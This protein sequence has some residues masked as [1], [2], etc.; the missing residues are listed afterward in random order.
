MFVKGVSGEEGEVVAVLDESAIVKIKANDSCEKCRL[1]K[2]VSSTEMEVEA[3]VDRPVQKG[4]RVIIAVKPGI[5][6]KSAL[7]LYLFPLI[8]MVGGYYLGKTILQLLHIS[9]KG[10]LVPAV[11]SFLFLFLSFVP[12][13]IY[14]RKKKTDRR[15][16]VYITDRTPA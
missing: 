9:A 15:F 11:F 13:R 5:V 14:D 4:E 3:L 2:R 12:I 6:F 7:I 1:C 10:E 16:R 8:G